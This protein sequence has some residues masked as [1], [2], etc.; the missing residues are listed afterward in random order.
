MGLVWTVGLITALRAEGIDPGAADRIIGTSAGAIVGTIIADGG[1]LDRILQPPSQEVSPP[2]VDPAAVTEVFGI[3]STPGIDASEALRRAGK[4][5][6]ELPLGDP[7]DH[8]A[9]MTG[10][11]GV[12]AWPGGDLVITVADVTA[13]RRRALTAADGVPVTRAVAASTCAPGV[14]APVPI[15]GRHYM[16]GGLHSPV[17]ADLAAGAEVIVVVEPLAHLFRRAPEDA[18]LGSGTVF[19]VIADAD[20]IGPDPFDTAALTPAYEAGVRQGH[21]VAP[22][23]REIWTA[24]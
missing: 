11:T 15:D 16:D 2:A 10:L 4:R 21:E 1:D 9:R 14:F 22:Q 19:S 5:A 13:G 23:L 17:N 24:G 3:L 6:L 7:E 12:T 8:V 20:A 18:D